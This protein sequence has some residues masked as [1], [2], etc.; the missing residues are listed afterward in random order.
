M[1]HLVLALLTVLPLAA[2]SSPA[3]SSGAFELPAAA[4]PFDAT[5]ARLDAVLG[6]YVVGDAVDYAA[7]QSERAELDLYLANLAQLDHETFAALSRE[8]R[9]AFWINVYNASILRLIAEHYPVDS[10]RDLGGSVF[11]RVWDQRLIPLGHLAPELGEANLS[12]TDVEHAILRPRFE[13]ARVH[14]AI[15]CASISC[16]PL[17]NRAFVAKSLEADLEEVM[18]A[19]VNDPTRNTLDDALQLSRAAA[20]PATRAVPCRLLHVAR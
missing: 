13:D 19:F 10:I 16:P 12:F 7:L 6:A 8:E 17:L 15:N 2:C 11:G 5:H 1:K 20:A 9:Y 3:G 4:E 18:R 14:A